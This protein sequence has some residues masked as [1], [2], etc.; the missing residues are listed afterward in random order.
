MS[1][2]QEKFIDQCLKGE[3]LADE[4]DDFVDV[5]HESEVG[6]P[7]HEFLGFTHDEY[8]LWVE[9]PDSLKFI[10]YARKHDRPLG[11]FRSVSEA[12]S[13]AARSVSPED[14]EELIDWLRRTG[15]IS[16]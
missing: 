6:V 4:I 15:R 16:D 10:L 13:M 1:H 11:D 3:A 9:R 8:A 12:Y 2:S 14:V 7:L 5:W